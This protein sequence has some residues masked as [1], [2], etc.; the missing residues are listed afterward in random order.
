MTFYYNNIITTDPT[1]LHTIITLGPTAYDIEGYAMGL[2]NNTDT[3]F[4]HSFIRNFFF[5]YM[6]SLFLSSKL[7]TLH[8]TTL[9]TNAQVL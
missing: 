4:F 7:L 3:L 1:V 9:Y 8:Y 6:F 5:I 2:T